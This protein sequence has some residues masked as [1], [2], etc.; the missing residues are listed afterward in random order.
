MTDTNKR[1]LPFAM[2]FLALLA[3]GAVILANKTTSLKAKAV[4]TSWTSESCRRAWGAWT[5]LCCDSYSTQSECE[6]A[7]GKKCVSFDPSVDREKTK[8]SKAAPAC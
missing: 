5:S 3:L 6:K 2:V 7:T 8:N 4:E 1:N